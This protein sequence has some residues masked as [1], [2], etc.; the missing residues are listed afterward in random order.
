MSCVTASSHCF[1]SLLPLTDFIITDFISLISYHCFITTVSYHCCMPPFP[2]TCVLPL[3]FIFH[4]PSHRPR[5]FDSQC[6]GR[7]GPKRQPSIVGIEKS[8][9]LHGMERH[10][11]RPRHAQLDQPHAP[12]LELFGGAGQRRRYV[13]FVFGGDGWW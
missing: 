9:G 11:E 5:L 12:T 8:L 10:V 7:I 2:T 1:L 6:R 4:P 13:A 3:V